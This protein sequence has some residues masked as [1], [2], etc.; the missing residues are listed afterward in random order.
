MTQRSDSYIALPLDFSLVTEGELERLQQA[1]RILSDSEKQLRLSSERST[2]FTA[3]LLQLG[4]GHNFEMNQS[5]SIIKHGAKKINDN[6][7]ELVKDSQ[8]CRNKSDSSLM[9]QESN[10]GLITRST[11]G[12]SSLHG[13]SSSYRMTMSENLIHDVL[14][15]PS[16]FVDRSLLDSTQTNDAP[17]KIVVRCVSPD[18]LG[19]IWR[20]CIQRCH[21]KTLKELLG[22]HGKLVS[23]TEHEGKQ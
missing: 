19:E 11:N 10:L 21:S 18:K 15:A 13:S 5:S 22:V 4:S 6:A 7:S 20:R 2:W 16:R 1:L 23:I 3:A 17:E 8:L 9:L 12:N 14:P